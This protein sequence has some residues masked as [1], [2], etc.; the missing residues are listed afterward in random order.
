MFPRNEMFGNIFQVFSILSLTN[1]TIL[2]TL[3]LSQKSPS[4]YV[5]AVQVFKSF[6]N[7]VG[8]GDIGEIAHYEQFLLFPLCF[9]PFM[10]PFCHFHQIQ[11]CCLHALSVWKSLKLVIW[12]RA[13]MMSGNDIS[14]LLLLL[15]YCFQRQIDQ[16]MFYLSS[17]GLVQ[18]SVA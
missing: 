13:K 10:I 7:T 18:N 16:A 4:F 5:S 6:E 11:N 9:L 12:E 14:P 15:S 8:K 2:A 3:T 1:Q 17:F